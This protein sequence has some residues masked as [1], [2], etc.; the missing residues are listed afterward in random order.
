[1]VAKINISGT[2]KEVTS[3]R[4]N[5]GGVNKEV[6]R[7][8]LNDNGVAK[9]VYSSQ[10]YEGV[11]VIGYSN[12]FG[13]ESQGFNAAGIYL[14]GSVSPSYSE[15]AVIAQFSATKDSSISVGI[16]STTLDLNTIQSVIG[17]WKKA[18]FGTFVVD[19]T[20][21]SYEV[22]RDALEDALSPGRNRGSVYVKDPVLANSLFNYL[23]GFRG[24]Q[25]SIQIK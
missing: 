5:D 17:S 20:S 7:V 15:D 21:T 23:N 4:F 2:G 1:M 22:Q 18:I 9:E 19:F 10:K 8:L 13:I 12:P 3:I 16:H 14:Y 25:I 24:A 11:M 6:S